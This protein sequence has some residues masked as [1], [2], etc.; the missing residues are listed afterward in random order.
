[1]L[2]GTLASKKSKKMPKRHSRTRQIKRTEITEA[3]RKKVDKNTKITVHTFKSKLF[4][5]LCIGPSF[6][7]IGP[8]K[9]GIKIK[10]SEAGWLKFEFSIPPHPI[11]RKARD[12]H[13]CVH[14]CIL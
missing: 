12:N 6:V 4:A 10:I 14:T 7:S 11:S 5:F 3:K 13:F 8:L 9:H 1:V 2:S